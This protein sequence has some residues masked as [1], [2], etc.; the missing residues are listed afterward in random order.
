MFDLI[1]AVRTFHLT[2]EDLVGLFDHIR[3]L[4]IFKRYKKRWIDGKYCVGIWVCFVGYDTLRI[5]H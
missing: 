2:V 4:N 3:I 1:L 5:G